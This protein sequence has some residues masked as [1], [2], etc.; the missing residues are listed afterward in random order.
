MMLQ[1]QRVFLLDIGLPGMDGKELAQHLRAQAGT[2]D[3][4][5]VAVTG[6]GQES[7]REQT[8]AAGFDHHLVEPVDMDSLYAILAKVGDSPG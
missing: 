7:D 4:V 1:C 6:Y 3:A 8:R 2:A 5:P